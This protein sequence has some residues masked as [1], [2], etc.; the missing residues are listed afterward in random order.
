MNAANELEMLAAILSATKNGALVWRQESPGR[1]EAT[2]IIDIVVQEICPLVAGDTDT[3]GVQAFQIE[4]NRLILTYW[5]GTGG[6]EKLFEILAA[7]LPELADHAS[8]S[9]LQIGEVIKRL[10]EKRQ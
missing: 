1:Y 5:S 10:N 2:G 8:L 9:S 4:V 6:C 7:G 3:A